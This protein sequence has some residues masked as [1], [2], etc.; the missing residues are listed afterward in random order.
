MLKKVINLDLKRI[1]AEL[2][3]KK[4]LTTEQLAALSG[5][6]RGTINK[7][8]NGETLNPTAK[9]LRKLALA[10]G[11]APDSL[12]GAQENEITVSGESEYDL[13]VV[14]T[15]ANSRDDALQPGDI[16]Y[17]ALQ[18]DVED[19]QLAAIELNGETHLMRIYHAGD[20]D[21]LIAT[22]K[23][24][25]PLFFSRSANDSIKIKGRAIAFQRSL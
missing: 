20:G 24:A 19:G 16:V 21:T 25:P 22:K 9:T 13:A 11:C 23:D 7:I 12:Y 8:L 18:D 5:V 14:V 10:L 2:K 3:D 4:Q 15:S 6:P 17:I 1:L